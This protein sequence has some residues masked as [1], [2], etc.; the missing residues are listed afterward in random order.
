[1]MAATMAGETFYTLRV[2]SRRVFY[3]IG[4]GVRKESFQ[5]EK[6]RKAICGHFGVI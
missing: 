3:S 5:N 2:S 6:H 1:M 4:V